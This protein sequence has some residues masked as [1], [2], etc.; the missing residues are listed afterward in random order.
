M[1]QK[2]V[3]GGVFKNQERKKGAAGDIQGRHF[4]IP[5][6]FR[7]L[8]RHTSGQAIACRTSFITGCMYKLAIMM[9]LLI[10]IKTWRQNT[11]FL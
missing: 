6:T 4:Q 1:C 7:R 11:P 2:C 9:S 8:D 5:D 10:L 3:G